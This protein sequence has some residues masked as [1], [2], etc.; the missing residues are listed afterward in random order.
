MVSQLATSAILFASFTHYM[1]SPGT[2]TYTFRV[3]TGSG[4]AGT[5][6]FNGQAA[7]RFYGGSLASSITIT[8]VVP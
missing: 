1:T 8:E 7:A 5:T 4:A 3:R 6:T 2:G